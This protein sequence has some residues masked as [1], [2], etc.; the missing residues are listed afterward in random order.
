M[1]PILGVP[2]PEAKPG[3]R[4]SPI[5]H[6]GIMTFHLE[7]PAFEEAKENCLGRLLPRHQI[8]QISECDER[9]VR[10]VVEPEQDGRQV[11][12]R[13]ARRAVEA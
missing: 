11:A 10:V 1:W 8:L 3:M 13:A 2:D 7:A 9:G 12:G 6:A 5:E 4:L